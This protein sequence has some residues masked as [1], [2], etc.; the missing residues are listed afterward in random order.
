MATIKTTEH[1]LANLYWA[2]IATIG[3]FKDKIL[4]KHLSGC[5]MKLPLSGGCLCGSLTYKI[6]AHP[7]ACGNCHCRTCQKTSASAYIAVLFVP[8]DALQ[9]S[10]K[11]QEFA[12]VSA[13]GNTVRRGFCPKCS[14]MLFA[15]NSASKQVRPVS[16]ASLDDPSIYH[17]QM[18]FWVADAQLW[19]CM[20]PDLPKYQH[21]PRQFTQG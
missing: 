1:L 21:Q 19:D 13:S 4:H 17:P 11:Y 3:K 18:D 2:I 15:T 6:T 16:V 9:I 12:T 8:Y 14:S 10:G 7:V 20:H 5:K